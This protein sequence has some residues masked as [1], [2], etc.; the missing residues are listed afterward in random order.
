MGSSRRHDLRP[1]VVRSVT[2]LPRRASQLTSNELR[3]VR[4]IVES[5]RGTDLRDRPGRVGEEASGFQCDAVVEQLLRGPAR[6]SVTRAVERARAVAEL[7]GERDD[8]RVFG[9]ALL[10]ELAE[11]QVGAWEVFDAGLRVGDLDDE[12]DQQGVKEDLHEAGVRR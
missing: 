10:D 5:E 8:R 4:R 12:A 6:G 2:N 9:Q 7:R 11:R 1:A 3:E